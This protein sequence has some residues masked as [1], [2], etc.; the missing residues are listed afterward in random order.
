M[1]SDTDYR[2]EGVITFRKGEVQDLVAKL[3]HTLNHIGEVSAKAGE[4]NPT[5]TAGRLLSLYNELVG[6]TDEHQQ[7]ESVAKGNV[8]ERAER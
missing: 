1:A 7:D 8:D 4:G 5:N 2:P 3:E 6:G